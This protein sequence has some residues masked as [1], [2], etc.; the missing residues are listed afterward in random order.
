[1]A[2]EVICWQ[3]KAIILQKESATSKGSTDI[4][5][6]EIKEVVLLEPRRCTL[7]IHPICLKIGKSFYCSIKHNFLFSIVT[8]DGKCNPL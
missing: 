5:G 8:F 1:M 6:A 2:G 4:R 3:E 7:N